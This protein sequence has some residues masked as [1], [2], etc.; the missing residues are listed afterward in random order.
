MVTL[1]V[2]A[3]NMNVLS[4]TGRCLQQLLFSSFG[5]PGWAVWAR[6]KRQV[7][8]RAVATFTIHYP[9]IRTSLPVARVRARRSA[10]LLIILN[11]KFMI[12]D[13]KFIILNTKFLVF[14]TQSLVLNTKFLV[15]DAD[16]I[17]FAPSES[18]L[19]APY[20]TPAAFCDI[21]PARSASRP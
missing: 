12:F 19:Y 9:T 16:F 18:P 14:D 11:T 4:G 8:W 5:A 1:P 3:T 17:I 21:D 10:L 20:R 13:T 6:T 2:G 15:F 7:R